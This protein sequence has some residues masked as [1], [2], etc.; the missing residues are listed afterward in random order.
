MTHAIQQLIEEAK[1]Q[2]ASAAEATINTGAGL[3]VTARLGEVE[4]IEHELDKA[5]VVTVYMG[6]KKGS[7]SSTDL[8]DNTVKSTVKAACDIAKLMSDDPCAGLADADLMAT[9]VLDMDLYHPWNLATEDAIQ[10]AIKCESIARK[11]D[12][13]IAN[14]DGTVVS[15]YA[16]SYFYGNSHGFIEGWHWSSHSIDCTVIAQTDS[17]MQCDGW[18]SKACKKEDLQS[19]SDIAKQA[20]KRTIRRLDARKIATQK[21]PV[22]FEASIANHLFSAFITAISGGSLYRKNSFLLDKIGQQIFADH[23]CI[24][25]RP[26]LQCALGSAPFDNEGVATKERDLVIDGVLQGYVLSSYSARKLD[27]QP[28]A[29]AG[30]VHNLCI[31]T[32]EHNLLT[33]IKEMD[34]GLLVTDIIGFGVNQMTG[35]YSRGIAGLWIEHGEI[36]Y[37]VEEVTVA[38]NLVDMYQQIIHVSNDI[39]YRKNIL[40]GSVLVDGMTIAGK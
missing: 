36:Q 5:L 30:G 26:H 20:V 12:K 39:D 29:N 25:E 40:T 31:D 13:R 8:S 28:T 17:V 35:D 19:I 10:L 3:T 18:Y 2:G 4:K 6:H 11:E 9:E 27:M 21:C 34:K 24:R 14:T 22:I 1:R 38:G 15:T 32:S 37:P 16:G 23:I 7:A 33:L